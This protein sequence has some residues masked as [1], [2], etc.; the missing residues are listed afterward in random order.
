MLAILSLSPAFAGDKKKSAN[1]KTTAAASANEIQWISLEE[2]QQKMKKEPRKVYFDI[3]TDWCGWCKVMDKKTLTNPEVIKYMN[4][5]YYAVKLNA[6]RK[7]EISFMGK[8]FSF[9]GEYRANMLAVELMRGQMSYPTTVILEE[10]YMNPQPVPGYLDVTVMEKVLKFFGENY[11]KTKKYE[12]FE[13]SFV[14]QW[15][16]A[17]NAEEADVKH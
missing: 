17:A 6:E 4:S 16:A 9:H 8:K 3:Y 7:D 11:Y 15:K 14:P 2:L 1:T 5:K 13:K 12:D 10:D